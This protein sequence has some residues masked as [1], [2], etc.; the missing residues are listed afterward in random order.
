MSDTGQAVRWSLEG[1]PVR[2]GYLCPPVGRES[3]DAL[4]WGAIHR[5]GI[6]A[7]LRRHFHV[8]A[9]IWYGLWIN[10]PLTREQCRLLHILFTDVAVAARRFRDHVQPFLSALREAADTG[11]PFAV[12]L[13]PP[14][15]VDMGWITTFVHCPRCKAEGPVPRWQESYPLEPVVCEV[16]GHSYSPAATYRMEREYF[17]NAVV[18][19]VCGTSHQVKD[20]KAEEIEILES[21]YYF[22]SFCEELDWL[23]RVAAFYQRH[24]ERQRRGKRRPGQPPPSEDPQ[25]GDEPV[26]GAPLEIMDLA[27]PRRAAESPPDWSAEDSEVLVYLRHNLFSLQPRWR[28]VSESIERLSPVV[29]SRSVACPSCGKELLRRSQSQASES[30]H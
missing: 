2:E 7:E 24:P 26:A 25:L 27:I 22:H 6:E 12:K 8:A 28:F 21:H 23:R 30:T 20:F 1:E 15:H 10:S 13:A 18:C 3:P 16:C 5:T 11:R 19:G 14:G 29:E 17:A 9:R 4:V